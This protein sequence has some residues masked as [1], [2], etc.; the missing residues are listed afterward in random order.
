MRVV[1]L[2]HGGRRA[3]G[4]AA[5]EAVRLTTAESVYELAWEAV[6]TG[7]R[8]ADVAASRLSGE[9]VE[10]ERDGW[11]W[12]ACV[13]HPEPARC[14]VSGTGLTHESSAKNRQAM[15]MA[16]EDMTDSMRMYMWGVEGGRPKAGE[17]GV[18]PEWFYKGRGE[19]LRGHLET[20]TWPAHAEDGG[21]E[22]ELAGIYLIDAEGRPRRIGIA[23][24]NEFSDHV[25]ERRNYLYLAESKL[26]ECSIGPE[27]WL[28]ADVSD[29]HG[30]A[31]V[32]RAGAEVWRQATRSGE[33]AMSHSL[34]N[35]EHHHF[36]H[37]PHR[38][39]GDVHVHFFGAGA[40]SFG[41]GVR[42]EDGDVMCVSFEGF[43]RPLRNPVRVERGRAEVVRVESL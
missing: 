22:A 2:T 14:L 10:P 34:A 15:H 17:A 36:K 9:I 19:V 21:E 40:F 11:L 31:W 29:V 8:L 16:A 12:L 24:G 37:A 4:I 32:E 41:D 3:A 6:R 33:A 27:L 38:R 42:L 1:Q 39:P 20:L 7:R 30:E 43:G 5:A 13:D 26:R 23:Q 28:D 35:I 25:H 18:A